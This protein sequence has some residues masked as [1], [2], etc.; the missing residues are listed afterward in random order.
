MRGVALPDLGHLPWHVRWR[1]RLAWLVGFR[2]T[3]NL[4]WPEYD[5][6]GWFNLSCGTIGIWFPSAW[7]IGYVPIWPYNAFNRV[8]EDT[9]E[10]CWGVGLLQIGGRHLLSVV[11]NSE[12]FQIDVAWIH[13]VQETPT[14]S[15]QR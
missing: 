8:Y 10:N 2:L 3:A 11:R 1:V 6:A 12:K 13:V 4:R 9:F 7:G 14:R 5:H 15:E